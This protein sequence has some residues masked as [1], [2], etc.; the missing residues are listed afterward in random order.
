VNGAGI[1]P[2]YQRLGGNA[3]L[4]S[5]LEKTISGKGY[6]HADLTQVAESTGLMLSD[7]KTLGGEIYK[8][9]R[10]FRYSLNP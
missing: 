9:H 4:Y 10:V 2:A 5:E 6:T 1:L 7:I 8:I 3:L